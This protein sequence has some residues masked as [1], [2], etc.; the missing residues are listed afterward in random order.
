MPAHSPT[1][2]F[3]RLM[4]RGRL[5]HLLLLVRVAELESLQKA[6]ESIGM[7]QPG[8]THALAEL[9][10]MLETPL[11]ERHAKGMR[12]SS[13]GHDLLPQVRQVV[14]AMQTCAET[15]FS[16]GMG[17]SGTV[18]VGAIGAAV[19]GVIALAL[20][21]F[22]EAHPEV[23]VDLAEVGADHLLQRVE[24]G[25]VDVLLCREPGQL[26]SGW[27]F[28]PL[29]NDR[30]VVICGPSHKLARSRH[31]STP[32]LAAQTWLHGPPTG[33]AARDFERLCE[34]LGI[35]PRFCWVHG[36]SLL[37]ML[38]LL[39]HR[40]LLAFMPLNTARQLIV[41]HLVVELPA[42]KAFKA[43]L[44][45]VGIVAPR[46][47]DRASPAVRHFVDHFSGYDYTR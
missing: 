29:V 34:A 28:R 33:L 9:E 14:A 1:V 23:V 43:E 46:S 31:V 39:Q 40:E 26:P 38:P 15:V 41:N 25:T 37:S 6:A 10:A 42:P 8:A 7:S 13:V 19:S 44:P 45:P 4:A 36:R 5:R 16:A 17:A 30:Y 11:F 47:L 3:A 35:V 27:T 2:F 21:A 32:Q 18:K 22:T 24:S 20:P 12:L